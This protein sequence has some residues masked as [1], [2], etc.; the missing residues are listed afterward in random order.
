M[1][2][3]KKLIL[4]IS[5]VFTFAAANL[6]AEVWNWQYIP[7]LAAG[8]GWTSY[9]T[10]ADPHGVS[11]R[12]VWVYFFDDNGQALTLN[13]DGTPKSVFSFQLAANQEMSFAITST[14]STVSGQVQIASQGTGNLNA[15][16]R[17]TLG[18][19]TE[20]IIDVIGVL[21][22]DPNY[23]WSLAIDKRSPDDDMGVAVANPWASSR[24][25][26][27]IF[28]L[29]QNGVRVPGTS[30]VSKPIEP[31]GHTA[32]FVSQLFPGANYSGT[33]TLKISASDS[34]SAM[35]LRGDETQYSSLSVNADVQFWSVSITGVSGTETWAYRF[36]DGFTFIGKGTNPNNDTRGFKLRGVR[37]SDL[38][39]PYF[40]AEWNYVDSSDGSQGIFLYQGT[41]S[42]ENNKDVINGTRV[43]AKLDGTIIGKTSFKAT[44][45]P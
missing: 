20:N 16:L 33:A 22:V 31:R 28:S 10:I 18:G 42:K 12:A 15:S 13:V 39:P 6:H 21:P 19:G 14:G 40:L 24:P 34:V 9:L 3:S 44:R 37:A 8:G 5:I 1:T 45:M 32:L 7:H 38:T 23:E 29:Y 36:V 27:V 11:S 35:A 17:F 25:T 4:I 30:P 43:Q 2:N 26:D 41:M